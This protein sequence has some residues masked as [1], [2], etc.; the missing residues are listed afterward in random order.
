M[1]AKIIR[2]IKVALRSIGLGHLL[3]RPRIP[4]GPE[5]IRAVGH[6]RYSGGMWEEIGKLQF[7]F[8]VSRGLKPEHV[9]CDVACGSLR[10]G[11]HLIPY[12]NP[13]NY[14]GIDKEQDLIDAGDKKELTPELVAEKQPEFVVS[15]AFEFERFSRQPQMAIAQSLFTHLPPELIRLC[16]RKL[17]PAMARGGEFYATFFRNTGEYAN[18]TEAHDHGFFAYTPGK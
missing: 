13:G 14:L 5:G 7:D 11:V 8:L 15:S 17:L 16:F 18:P 10:A 4:H 1:K 6:R 3:N 12:L 2:L 9:F